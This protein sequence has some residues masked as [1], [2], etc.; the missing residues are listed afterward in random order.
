MD[1]KP[2]ASLKISD[3]FIGLLGL[4]IMVPLFAVPAQAAYEVVHW[5]QQASW[6]NYDWYMLTGYSVDQVDLGSDLQ[7]A[8]AILRW[9]MDTW[10]SLPFTIVAGG[11]FSAIVN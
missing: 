3:L 2:T 9:L 1:E 4:A 11:I 7:G 6:L 8:T 5:L 10:V